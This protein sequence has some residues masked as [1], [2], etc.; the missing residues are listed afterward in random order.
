MHHLSITW[1]CPTS[2]QFNILSY[3]CVRH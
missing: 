3:D 2:C 1:A